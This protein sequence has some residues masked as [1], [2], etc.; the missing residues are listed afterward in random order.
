MGPSGQSRF[1]L[2]EEGIR[3]S[4]QDLARQ[5][6]V[7]ED[8]SSEGHE[9]TE[10]EAVLKRFEAAHHLLLAKLGALRGERAAAD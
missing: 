10:A 3:K 1:E 5:R 9:T 8:L 6:Q 4:E 2:L 7:I